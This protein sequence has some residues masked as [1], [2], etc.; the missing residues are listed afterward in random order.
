MQAILNVTLQEIDQKF[1]TILRDLLSKNIEVVIKKET[2]RVEEFDQTKPLPV[3]MEQLAKA[4]Y[5]A[6]LLREIHEGLKTSSVYAE[7]H[8]D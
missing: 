6:E 3:V 4:G 7:R 2:P 5:H 1:L 8:E